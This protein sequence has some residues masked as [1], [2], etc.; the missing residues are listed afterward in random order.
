LIFFTNK[1]FI[2]RILLKFTIGLNWLKYLWN[3][4]NDGYHKIT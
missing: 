2:F 3:R 1:F 4:Y